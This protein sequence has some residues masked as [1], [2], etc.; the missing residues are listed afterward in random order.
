[1]AYNGRNEQ[2]EW[3]LALG[4]QAQSTMIDIIGMTFIPMYMVVE[5]FLFFISL[6]LM[7]WGGFR[8]IITVCL[9]VAIITRC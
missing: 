6:L 8:F 2:G 1:M 4:V 7:V 9:R 5:P 3:G